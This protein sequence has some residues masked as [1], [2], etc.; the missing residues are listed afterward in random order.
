MCRISATALNDESQSHRQSW[1]YPKSQMFLFDPQ[2]DGCILLA[3]RKNSVARSYD[4][5]LLQTRFRR[6][7]KHHPSFCWKPGIGRKSLYPRFLGISGPEHGGGYA[8]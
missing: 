2:E 4:I 3:Q 8:F 6:F 1:Q 7:A 5:R